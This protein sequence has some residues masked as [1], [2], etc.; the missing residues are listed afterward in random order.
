MYPKWSNYFRFID[1]G[2]IYP[3]AAVCA[4]C[5]TNPLVIHLINPAAR[6]TQY[7][8]RTLLSATGPPLQRPPST[9]SR[10]LILSGNSL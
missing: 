7:Q 5:R 2:C 10:A 3:F 8:L 9:S 6:G 1:F 4:T